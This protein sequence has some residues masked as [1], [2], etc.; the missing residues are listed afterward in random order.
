MTSKEIHQLLQPYPN[1]H[2]FFPPEGPIKQITGCP[3]PH[4]ML[5]AYLQGKGLTLIMCGRLKRPSPIPLPAHQLYNGIAFKSAYRL[6]QKAGGDILICS[7]R[8][9]LI[10]PDFL[11][12]WYDHQLQ[13]EDLPAFIQKIR[14][15]LEARQVNRYPWILCLMGGVYLEAFLHAGLPDLL[16]SPHV[17]LP[18]LGVSS[19]RYYQLRSRLQS[20]FKA[21]AWQPIF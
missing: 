6:G 17:L 10:D 3:D 15:Q 16:K 7:A 18:F 13:E 14:P 21:Q 2:T 11:S 1:F 4:P 19:F 5:K 9:G 20:Y 8:H 12:P